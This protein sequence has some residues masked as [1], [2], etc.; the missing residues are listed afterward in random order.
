MKISHFSF[1]AI[2]ATSLASCNLIPSGSSNA[3][4]DGQATVSEANESIKAPVGRPS[5][6]GKKNMIIS[7]YRPYNLI[8]V[9]GYKSGDIVG[10]PSTASVDATTGKPILSTSKHFRLP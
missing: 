10:D 2:A 7:P 1:L 6:D 4:A 8:D 5:P 3:V 9:S